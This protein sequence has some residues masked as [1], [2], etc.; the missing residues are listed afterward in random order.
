M[1]TLAPVT[2]ASGPAVNRGIA[3]GFAC[4][5]ASVDMP[6]GVAWFHISILFNV[7]MSA[8]ALPKPAIRASAV[9]A[10]SRRFIGYPLPYRYAPLWGAK[11]GPSAEY[12]DFCHTVAVLL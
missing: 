9:D 11:F 4:C 1:L 5:I 10:T 6:P 7:I 3:A 8:F 2:F 12:L